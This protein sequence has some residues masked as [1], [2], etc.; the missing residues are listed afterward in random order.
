MNTYLVFT[1]LAGHLTQISFWDFPKS[2]ASPVC[3]SIRQDLAKS[4]V[5]DA[6]CV[7][8]NT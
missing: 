8:G 4:G 3:E 5:K 2:L 6:E 7:L 1:D